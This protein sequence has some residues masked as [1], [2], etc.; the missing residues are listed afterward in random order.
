MVGFWSNAV[1]VVGGLAGGRS[2]LAGGRTSL[3][4]FALALTAT[5]TFSPVVGIGNV[6]FA[7]KPEEVDELAG[8]VL[9]SMK[10]S[11]SGGSG[12]KCFGL[13]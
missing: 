3:F 4:A 8:A 1:L 5:V 12:M 9:P 13:S 10:N 6:V 2:G 7:L 11:G